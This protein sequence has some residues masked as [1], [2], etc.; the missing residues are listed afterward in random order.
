MIWRYAY[1]TAGLRTKEVL[2]DK[3][4]KQTGRIDYAYSPAK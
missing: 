1:N 3:N 2:F 4:K